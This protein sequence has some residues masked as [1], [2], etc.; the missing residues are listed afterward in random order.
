M[1][2]S[3]W[4]RELMAGV[5]VI[6]DAADAI[7]TPDERTL[8]ACRMITGGVVVTGLSNG[9]TPD[10]SLAVATQTLKFVQETVRAIANER[11]AR[12]RESN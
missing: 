4:T 12:I 9:L 3:Q 6:V 7:K 1:N 10:E 5:D 2:A 11:K 8:Y